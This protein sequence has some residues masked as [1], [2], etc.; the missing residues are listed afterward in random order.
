MGAVRVRLRACGCVC[1]FSRVDCPLS[2]SI[3]QTTRRGE[4]PRRRRRADNK[5]RLPHALVIEMAIVF[6]RNVCT[7]C[8]SILFYTV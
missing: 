5:G 1:V 7:I 3:N 6:A 4:L 8:S 2:A